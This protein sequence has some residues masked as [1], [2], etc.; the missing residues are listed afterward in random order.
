MDK[1]DLEFYN[2]LNTISEEEM[3]GSGLSDETL[4]THI[5][6]LRKELEDLKVSRDI[7]TKD[8]NHPLIKKNAQNIQRSYYHPEKYEN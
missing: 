7:K 8:A 6:N 1:L 4:I 2:Y 3:L 5:F